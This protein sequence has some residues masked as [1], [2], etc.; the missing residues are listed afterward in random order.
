MANYNRIVLL[1]NLTRTPESRSTQ[2]GTSVCKL[3]LAVN[4]KFKDTEDT[5]FVDCVAFGKVGEIIQ[6][7]CDK[8]DPLLIEGRLSFATWDDKDG[9]GKRS[10]HEVVVENMQLLRGPKDGPESHGSRRTGGASKPSAN[11]DADPD[12]GDI[13]F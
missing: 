10:K 2:S 7:Y 1:G 5:C 6:Q 13:P 3:G 11:S 12:Y 4:R 8:G 9:G